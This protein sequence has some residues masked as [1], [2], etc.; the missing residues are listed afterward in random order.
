MNRS[1]APKAR[2]AE[3]VAIEEA[4]HKAGFAEVEAKR[5]NSVSLRIRVVDPRFK[6]Q[7]FTQRDRMVRKVI[8]KLPSGTQ[9]DLTL[10]LLLAPEEMQGSLINADFEDPTLSRL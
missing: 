8:D 3:L 9:E 2:P 4:F 5:Q 6:D 1:K 10:V 7:S